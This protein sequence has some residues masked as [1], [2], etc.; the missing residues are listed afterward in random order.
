MGI[1]EGQS[2]VPISDIPLITETKV[3]Q[4]RVGGYFV[5]VHG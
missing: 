2:P 5:T 3:L 4:L 1:Q